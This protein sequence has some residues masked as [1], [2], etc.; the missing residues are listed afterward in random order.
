MYHIKQIPEDFIVKEIMDLKLE[1]GRYSY[2]LLKKKSYN[3]I[4]AIRVIAKNFRINRKFIN[5]AGTKDRNAITEQYISI[6]RGP[7]KDLHLKDIDVKFLGTG[8]ERLNLGTLEGNEF[9]I[10]IR[11]IKTKP[12]P[13]KEILNLFD[14]QRFG[15]KQNNHIIGK[16]IVKKEFAEAVKLIDDEQLSEH[17]NKHPND[18]IGALKKLPKQILRLYVHA[19]QSYLWNQMAKDSIEHSIPLIGFETTEDVEILQNEGISK[20]DFLIRQIPE[21]S[22][23]GA[24]R[25][26]TTKVNNLKV[27]ELEPDELNSGM[28]K[29]T[30]SFSLQKGSY[31]TQ[32]IKQMATDL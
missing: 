29:V 25:N 9:T 4:D 1:P 19:Y 13:I 8:T 31:A 16:A 15:S 3:T 7:K 18:Y 28:N 30:V 11:N 26:R 21:I 5:F 27:S 12:K 32:V 6:S 14:A 23:E 20:I 10:V 24:Y 2:Y 17:L 22:S